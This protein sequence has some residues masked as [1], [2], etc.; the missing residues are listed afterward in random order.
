LLAVTAGVIGAAALGG[1]AGV[2]A[3]SI[4][5]VV[6]AAVRVDGAGTPQCTACG[7]ANAARA[8]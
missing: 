4:Q 5:A 1:G 8:N 6:G 3:E 2:S 7:T